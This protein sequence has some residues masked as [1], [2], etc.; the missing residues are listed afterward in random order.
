MEEKKENIFRNLKK[1]NAIY[2]EMDACKAKIKEVKSSAVSVM[3]K[4]S[5]KERS[6][7]AEQE[8]ELLAKENERIAEEAAKIAE[9]EI[10]K[11]EAE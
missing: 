9:A 11:A 7:K 1:I 10:A 6:I 4:L 8:A 2:G 5:N 3:K